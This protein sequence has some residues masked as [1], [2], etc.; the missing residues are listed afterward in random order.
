MLNNRRKQNMNQKEYY[1]KLIKWVED[2]PDGTLEDYYGY[3]DKLR[4]TK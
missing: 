2:H 1:D 4:K 3:R